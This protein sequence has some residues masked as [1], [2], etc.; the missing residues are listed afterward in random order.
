MTL[1]FG[2]RT[3]PIAAG[4]GAGGPAEHGAEGADAFITEIE[5]HLG[6]RRAAA[7]SSHRFQHSRLL[8]PGAE[9]EAGFALEPPRERTTAGVDAFRPCGERPLITRRLEQCLPKGTQV[10]V[11]RP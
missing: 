2:V 10:A 9:A 3:I 11:A 8:P 4:R 6:D 5:R 1:S 7:Q